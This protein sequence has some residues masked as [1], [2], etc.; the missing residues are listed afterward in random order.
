MV[1]DDLVAAAAASGGAVVMV[2]INWQSNHLE[3]TVARVRGRR[4]FFGHFGQFTQHLHRNAICKISTDALR[5]YYDGA[6]KTF[7]LDSNKLTV[8]L[9]D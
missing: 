9:I 1:V 2:S 7:R 6:I 5:Y 3:V 8:I 4:G